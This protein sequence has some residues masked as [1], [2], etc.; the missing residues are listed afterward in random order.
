MATV[1]DGRTLVCR[2]GSC[3]ADRFTAGSGV[4]IAADGKLQGVSVN[5]RRGATLEELTSTI[6]NRRVGVTNIALIAA[7]GGSVVSAPMPNNPDHCVLGGITRQQAEEL[8]T[9]TISNPNVP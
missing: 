6:P 8:F 1:S 9:P 3:T 4:S 2:G 5:S 7:A